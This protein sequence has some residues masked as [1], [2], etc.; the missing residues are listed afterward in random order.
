MSPALA[1]PGF[2]PGDMS[3]CGSD[4]RVPCTES[5]GAAP[6]EAY[7]RRTGLESRWWV[8]PGLVGFWEW[9][10]RWPDRALFAT[11]SHRLASAG[12][13]FWLPTKQPVPGHLLKGTRPCCSALS[14]S[15]G[16]GF[17]E[18][19]TFSDGDRDNGGA[20]DAV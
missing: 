18:E 16:L 9:E 17:L 2:K 3:V 20:T 7:R 12:T 19:P 6:R 5:G 13:F 4:G 8:G 11:L 14:S 15:Q 1:R 10:P